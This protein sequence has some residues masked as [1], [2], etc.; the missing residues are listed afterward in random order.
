MCYVRTLFS[1]LAVLCLLT[2]CPSLAQAQPWEILLHAGELQFANKTGG[3][4]PLA[5]STTAVEDLLLLDD[6]A[7]KVGSSTQT[8]AIDVFAEDSVTP[9]TSIFED[10]DATGGDGGEIAIRGDTGLESAIMA[11]DY[12]GHGGFLR[13]SG[14]ASTFIVDGHHDGDGQVRVSINGTSLVVFDASETGDTSVELPTNAL[15]ATEIL[16]EPGVVNSLSESAVTFGTTE[17]TVLSQTLDAPAAGYA[18]V[19][20]TAQ[21]QMIHTAGTNTSC[22]VGVSDVSSGLPV[23]QDVRSQIASAA[24]TGVY[25]MPATAHGVF[26]VTAGSSTFY[27]LGRENSGGFCQALDKNLSIVFIPTAY[28]TVTPNVPS[29]SD[30]VATAREPAPRATIT[31]ADVE[32]QRAQSLADNQARLARELA[33]MQERL[34]ALQAELREISRKEGV[35][36]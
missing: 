7:I 22:D 23:A 6:D 33:V 30:P 32:T 28:G 24:P 2:F 5:V 1:P 8:G 9:V 18:L 19:I 20:G 12:D 26:S 15:N 25:D 16:D 21:L 13:V 17:T 36:Q 31:K 4:V 27:L 14:V 35:Q 29:A 11:N 10:V 34:E 3:V